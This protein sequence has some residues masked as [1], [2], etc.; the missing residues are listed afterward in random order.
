MTETWAEPV[1]ERANATPKIKL[2]KIARLN[3]ALNY[4][5]RV[6]RASILMRNKL[7]VH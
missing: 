3:L 4:S 1:A 6:Q 5:E 7:I 2:I